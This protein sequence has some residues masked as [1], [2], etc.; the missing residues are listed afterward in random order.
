MD[1]K[2]KKFLQLLEMVLL[3]WFEFLKDGDA[4]T[5]NTLFEVGR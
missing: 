1:L 5:Q 3:L 4:A 2:R